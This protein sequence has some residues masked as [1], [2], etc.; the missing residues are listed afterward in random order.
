V[1][2]SPDGL[3]ASGS[4]D[5]TIRLWNTAA[6]SRQLIIEGHS[7]WVRSVAFPTD[8]RLLASGSGDR[9]VRLW[10]T[11]TG[12]LRRTFE[13]HSGSVQSVALSCN[14]L[15]ASGS[16]DRTIRLWNTATGAFQQSLKGHSGSIESVAFSP[17]GHVLAF[18]SG[19]QC[20]RLWNIDSQFGNPLYVHSKLIN[21]TEAFYRCWECG[22][23]THSKHVLKRHVSNSHHP[24]LVYRCHY[25]DCTNLKNPCHRRDKLLDHYRF[26]H[27]GIS[28]SD[29]INN[30]RELL[31][32]PPICPICSIT[33]QTCP[34]FY[35]C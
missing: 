30:K 28:S 5:R 11:A 29:I 13:G 27:G 24:E 12:A 22:I 17:D 1:A 10:N 16:S 23:V 31:P 32:C 2:L 19:D 25:E 7:N 14:G 18:S 6:G 3:L 35:E 34:E 20:V 15:L 26:F 9:S 33:I 4:G 8:G 21:E